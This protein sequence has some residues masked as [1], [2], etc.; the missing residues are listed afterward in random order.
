MVH[1][2]GDHRIYD[3]NFLPR[4]TYDYIHKTVMKPWLTYLG[5]AKVHLP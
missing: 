1:V 3:D 2:I 4:N 5:A